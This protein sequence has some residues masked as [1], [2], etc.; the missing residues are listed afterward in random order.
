MENRGLALL[1]WLGS[2][3]SQTDGLRRVVAQE[4]V[5]AARAPPSPSPPSPADGGG[6]TPTKAA[7]EGEAKGQGGAGAA[8]AAAGK[9]AGEESSPATQPQRQQRHSDVFGLSTNLGY[10]W[11]S[12]TRAGGSKAVPYRV[13]RDAPLGVLVAADP[14]LARPLRQSLH[15]LLMRLLVDQEFKR[16]FALAFARLYEVGAVQGAASWLRGRLCRAFVG[17][18]AGGRAAGFDLF[19]LLVVRVMKR[20]CFLWVEVE[21]TAV[22]LVVGVAVQFLLPSSLELFGHR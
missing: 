8:A 22:V 2:L 21:R 19:M 12:H 5:A 17:S 15:G 14:M 13:A 20:A 3:C 1:S 6:S 11:V 10:L 16:D 7:V 4:L 18:G 9:A